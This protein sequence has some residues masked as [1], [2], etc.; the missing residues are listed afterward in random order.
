MGDATEEP[1]FSEE[2]G[3]TL[4]EVLIVIA[5]MGILAAIAI[6]TWQG[7]TEGRRVDSA[8]NQLVADMRLSNTIAT[9]RLSSSYMIFNATGSTVTCGGQQADYCL[10]KPTSSGFQV[11]RRDLPDDNNAASLPKRLLKI[12]SSNMTTDP[13]GLSIPD[14]VGNVTST[15]EFKSDGSA[16]MLGAAVASPMVTV[17]TYSDP[18]GASQTC[19]ASHAKPCHDIQITAS[20]SRVKVAY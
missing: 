4:P 19:A 17:R 13:T 5:I 10:V 6:P 16:R 12:T 1:G 8:A 3:F 7:I 11:Q 2:R 20:T 14:V 18:A 15:V 9:N